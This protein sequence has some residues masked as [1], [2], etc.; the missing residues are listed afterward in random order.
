MYVWIHREVL[1]PYLQH[2][3]PTCSIV[4]AHPKYVKA[5]PRQ[6]D[7][8]TGCKVDLPTSSSTTLSP[9]VLFLRQIIRQL[10]DLVRYR[11]K[12]TNV[13]TGEKN[14]AHI[15]LTVSA[16]SWMMC[17]QMCLAKATSAITVRILE[18]PKG[19]ITDVSGFRTKRHESDQ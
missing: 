18:N 10:R 7:R 1:V 9:G 5:I 4:L 3:R 14:R 8:Q 15:C 12:L 16:S 6:E 11:W 17:F 2:L 13:T 19:K